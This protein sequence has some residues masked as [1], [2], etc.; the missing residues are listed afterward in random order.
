MFRTHLILPEKQEDKCPWDTH[1]VLE[2]TRETIRLMTGESRT[3]IGAWARVHFSPHYFFNCAAITPRQ[4]L[5]LSHC[6]LDSHP[7]TCNQTL[8]DGLRSSSPELVHSRRRPDPNLKQPTGQVTGRPKV[9]WWRWYVAQCITR[10]SSTR[11]RQTSTAWFTENS[12]ELCT[13]EEGVLFSL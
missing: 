11:S 7:K 3:H 2:E 9:G 5:P 8:A 12:F 13:R 10:L 1:R 6:S 4:E